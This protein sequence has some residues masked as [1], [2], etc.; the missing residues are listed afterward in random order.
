MP[1]SA[2]NSADL[3]LQDIM[4]R[5]TG[6]GDEV[7]SFEFRSSVH[8]TEPDSRAFFDSENMIVDTRYGQQGCVYFSL[9]H[10]LLHHEDMLFCWTLF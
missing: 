6:E 9:L 1:Q 4:A 5:D 3:L 2:R 7:K 8:S 10:L